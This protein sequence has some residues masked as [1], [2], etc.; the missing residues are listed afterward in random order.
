M[1]WR[2]I[3]AL[4]LCKEQ[5]R[6]RYHL[7]SRF[8]LTRWFTVG[9]LSPSKAGPKEGAAASDAFFWASLFSRLMATGSGSPSPEGFHCER[10]E[11]HLEAAAGISVDF[12]L[13]ISKNTRHHVE[14]RRRHQQLLLERSVYYL[15]DPYKIDPRVRW[16]FVEDHCSEP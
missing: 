12:R 15:P 8:V 2:R 4:P 11:V 1:L 9:L 3:W 14:R 13:L 10:R 5:D 16:H 6:A 7:F